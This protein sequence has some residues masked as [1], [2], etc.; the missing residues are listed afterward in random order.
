[1]KIVDVMQ[2]L[3]VEDEIEHEKT[4]RRVYIHGYDS[5]I[6]DMRRNNVN[7]VI[8]FFNNTLMKWRYGKKPYNLTFEIP[9]EL[10]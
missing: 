9:P 7:K 4:F 2:D 1:M 10:K 8:G 3:K 5:A 6:D